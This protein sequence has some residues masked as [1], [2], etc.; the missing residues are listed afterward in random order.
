M[1]VGGTTYWT[2][3]GRWNKRE[4]HVIVYA[5]WKIPDDLGL[6]YYK[7]YEL[8]RMLRW[9][10]SDHIPRLDAKVSFKTMCCIPKISDDPYSEDFHDNANNLANMDM[11]KANIDKSTSQSLL[12]LAM[13]STIDLVDDEDG[14]QNVRFV[15][16]GH[17]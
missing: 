13:K 2:E 1:Y 3:D 8:E 6:R 16:S 7:P 12:T 4:S 5:Q 15:V 10:G 17:Q 9:F 14:I 11:E